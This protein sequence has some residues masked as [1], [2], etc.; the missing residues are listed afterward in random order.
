MCLAKNVSF[1]FFCCSL[2]ALG[3]F[4]RVYVSGLMKGGADMFVENMPDFLTISDPAAQGD[5]GLP[6]QPFVL[7][8][9]FLLWISYLKNLILR[10]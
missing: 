10:E 8:L 9:G 5:T 1:N 4:F 2:P 7:T 6:H 3:M